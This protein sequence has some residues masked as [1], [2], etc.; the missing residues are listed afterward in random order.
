MLRVLFL[1]VAP[2]IAVPASAVANTPEFP[3]SIKEHKFDPR[4]VEI[5]A[6]TKV[7]L[8]VTNHDLTPEEFESYDFN[9]EKVIDGQGEITLFVG[10]LEPGEYKFFGEF[11]Q[12]SAQGK[13]IVK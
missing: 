1:I 4:L 11:H 3:I 12:E 2:L 13:L 5:P 6:N 9:R 8:R 10:P 7:K